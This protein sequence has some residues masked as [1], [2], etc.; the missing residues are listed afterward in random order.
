[1]SDAKYIEIKNLPDFCNDD[2]FLSIVKR[3]APKEADAF[4]QKLLLEPFNIRK[5]IFKSSCLE[6]IK[7][8]LEDEV[9]K[10][11]KSNDFYINWIKDMAEV[12]SLYCDTLNTNRIIFSLESSRSCRRFHIDNVPTR[13]LVTYYGKGTE[14]FPNYACDYDAYYKGKRLLGKLAS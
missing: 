7:Y 9:S 14:W 10:K 8:I 12:C 4:F 3:K 13:L 5:I 11:L 6:T 1:M 2:S